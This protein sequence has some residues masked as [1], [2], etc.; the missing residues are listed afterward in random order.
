[1]IARG[2]V[3]SLTNPKTLFFYAAFLPQFV[4]G[5]D[6]ARQMWILAATFVAIAAIVDCG[7]A[8]LAGR[9]R[10]LL[11]RHARLRGRL[12]GTVLIAAGAGLALAR[13]VGAG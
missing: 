13:R 10:P 4:T 7:W 5:A 1:M 6:P 12:T 9:L 8:L 11:S 2:F 3:V